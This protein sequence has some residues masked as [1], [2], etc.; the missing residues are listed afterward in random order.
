MSRFTVSVTRKS[1]FTSL[2]PTDLANSRRQPSGRGGLSLLE[3]S[4]LLIAM[5]LDISG[6]RR[7]NARV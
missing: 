4:A 6:P 7:L 1:R 5:A 2:G 3:P